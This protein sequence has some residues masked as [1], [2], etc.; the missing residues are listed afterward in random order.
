[1]YIHLTVCKQISSGLLEMLPTNYLFLF[2]FMIYKKD[3]ALDNPQEFH[4]ALMSL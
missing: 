3:L 1:M 4:F 2:I